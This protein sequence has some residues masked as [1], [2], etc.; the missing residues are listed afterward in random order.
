MAIETLEDIAEEVA[1]LAGINGIGPEEGNHPDSCK[2]RICFTGNLINRMK[3]AARI[4]KILGD[5]YKEHY[6]G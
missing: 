1:D 2:C 5:Y 4:D 6:H 3:E